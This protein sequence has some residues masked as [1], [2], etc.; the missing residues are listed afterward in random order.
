MRHDRES[1][2]HE[3][4]STPSTFKRYV[5]AGLVATAVGYGILS[6]QAKD[7]L[8][9]HN[10]S[11]PF[12]TNSMS[13]AWS[14][15]ENSAQIKKSFN[16]VS[17]LEC[18]DIPESQ[19]CGNP[20]GD[21]LTLM[22]TQAFSEANHVSSYPY[23]DNGVDIAKKDS[24]NSMSPSLQE[25]AR[26]RTAD[27]SGNA[28]QS[29]SQNSPVYAT[30]SGTIKTN[31]TALT[32][33]NFV[34]SCGNSGNY[35]V[36]GGHLDHYSD[37]IDDGEVE[38][39]EIVGYVGATGRASGPHLHYSVH[40]NGKDVDPRGERFHFTSGVEEVVAEEDVPE[41]TATFDNQ[42]LEQKAQN[43]KDW[44]AQ[45]TLDRDLATRV[46]RSSVDANTGKITLSDDVVDAIVLAVDDLKY[47]KTNKD[48]PDLTFILLTTIIR[49]TGGTL[50]KESFGSGTYKQDM[51]PNQWQI[52][53]Q[54]VD[55]WNALPPEKNPLKIFGTP[56]VDASQVPV[57]ARPQNLAGDGGAFGIFQSI[58][59]TW[60]RTRSHPGANPWDLRDGAYAAGK[61]L[62]NGGVE[63]DPREGFRHYYGSCSGGHAYECDIRVEL[64]T[65]L[66][67]SFKEY[68]GKKGQTSNYPV[69]AAMVIVPTLN[70]SGNSREIWWKEQ[71]AIV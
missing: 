49:E 28:T 69:P 70:I 45:V 47:E 50:T 63:D 38:R 62:L 34:I 40:E 44:L 61:E 32:G 67:Q 60:M 51:N 41:E 14:R 27:E 53:E 30:C 37:S 71:Q 43:I 17:F 21:P 13:S 24:N 15:A 35:E 22:I 59:E 18:V 20:L 66:Q 48:T 23:F 8:D 3:R 31:N 5:A 55:E 52:F 33:N 54:L 68:M 65:V 4:R 29:I 16:G 6:G 12:T 56:P 7:F 26:G 1:I 42:E 64:A 19:P 58:P 9:S 57:S 46:D 39:G 25:G 10:I 11:I 2:F 36:Y